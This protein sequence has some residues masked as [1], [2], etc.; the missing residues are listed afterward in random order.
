MPFSVV[1]P[2]GSSNGAPIVVTHTNPNA[3][4]TL[5]HQCHAT[6]PQEVYVWFCNNS[7]ATVDVTLQLYDGAT[8]VVSEWLAVPPRQ[9]KLPFEPGLRLTALS[10]RAVASVAGVIVASVN[11]NQTG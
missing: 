10:V 9:G 6:I 2:N 1:L 7:S 8:H 4:G 3:A 11:I 5:L